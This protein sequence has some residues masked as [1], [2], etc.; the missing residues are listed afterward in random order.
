MEL[1]EVD[2]RLKFDLNFIVHFGQTV[3]ELNSF[4]YQILQTILSIRQDLS[5]KLCSL[6]LL[7]IH[8]VSTCTDEAIAL[9]FRLVFIRMMQTFATT[10]FPMTWLW[11]I[12]YE[13]FHFQQYYRYSEGNFEYNIILPRLFF[14]ECRL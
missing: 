9:E 1:F 5:N 4:R 3:A 11:L 7:L 6:E 2:N 8:Y 10:G 14:A 13:I 12:S